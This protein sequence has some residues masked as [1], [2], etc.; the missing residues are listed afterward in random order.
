ML[1]K[2]LLF[3]TLAAIHTSTMSLTHIIFDLCSMP[4]YVEMLRKEITEVIGKS[5]WT[6]AAVNELKLL[7]SFMKESQRVNHPGLCK[8]LKI[9]HSTV[10]GCDF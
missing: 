1:V 8:R 6:L 10:S 5:G 2:K 7:D 4:A 3:L 9:V